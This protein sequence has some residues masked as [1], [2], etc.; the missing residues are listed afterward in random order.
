MQSFINVY[1]CLLKCVFFILLVV[2]STTAQCGLGCAAPTSPRDTAFYLS[3][4]SV[5]VSELAA[6]GTNT[7]S[8]SVFGTSNGAITLTSG[9]YFSKAGSSTPE[10]PSSLPSGG[11]VA[12]TLSAWV[13]CAPPAIPWSAVLEW[14]LPSDE[15]GSASPSTAALVVTGGEKGVSLEEFVKIDT[16]ILTGFKPFAIVVG[17]QKIYVLNTDSKSV[18]ILT[19]DGVFDTEMLI[20]PALNAGALTGLAVHSVNDD[21]YVSD[22]TEKKIYKLTPTPDGLGGSMYSGNAFITG[23]AGP[24]GVAFDSLGNVYVSEWDGSV[25]LVKKFNTNVGNAPF[26]TPSTDFTGFNEPYGLA[27]DSS[28]N[29]YV[30]DSG[31][32]RI[33]KITSQGV[34]SVVATGFNFPQGVA[35]D[36][37]GNLYVADSSN[38]LI[39]L[40]TP[41]LPPRTLESGLSDPSGIAVSPSGTIFFTETGLIK[42]I[43]KYQFKMFLPACDSTWHHVALTYEPALIQLKAYIDGN[44]IIKKQTPVILP[45]KQSCLL[46]IGFN[47]DTTVPA[48]FFEGSLS[49]LRIYNRTLFSSEIESLSQPSS[50]TFSGSNLISQFDFTPGGSTH[51]FS[52]A[53]GYAGPIAELSLSA[54]DNSHYWGSAPSCTQCVAGTWSSPGSTSCSLCPPGTYSSV[55]ASSCTSCNAGLYSSI[56]A[57]SCSTCQAC[58]GTGVITFSACTVSSNSICG[59]ASGYSQSGSSGSNLVC[60]E[61]VAGTWS[62]PGS[63]S[64]SLCPPGTYSSVGASSCT[65]CNAGLY[66]SIG[67]GS[68]STCQ[69]CSG[70]GVITFSACTVSSN[71]ICGC[72]S[73]YSQSGSSG[74]N[75][76]CTECVAGTWS[77]PGS[78][79]CSLCPPGTYSSVG[80]SSCT[81]CNAG[82]YSSIGA[83]SCSTCQACSGTGVITFSACTVSS[84]SICG[85][86]SGYSQSGSSGSNLVCTECVA[87][88]WS[89]P[90]STSCS[91]CP[92][93]TYSS[94]GASSCT[95]CNAGFYSSIGAGS[96]T[97]CQTCSGTGVVIISP[98]TVSS[99]AICG[100]ASGHTQS[101]TSGSNLVCTAT[102]SSSSSSSLPTCSAGSTFLSSATGTCTACQACTGTGVITFSACTVSSNSICGCASGYSQSG[103]SGSNLVCTECVAGKWSSPGSTS[104]SL[105]PPGTYSTSGASSCTSCSAGFY[106]SIGAGSCTSC[107]T[108]SGTGVVIISPCTVSSNAICGCASG[109]TQSGTSGSNLICT[110]ALPTCSAGSTFLSSATGTCVACQACTG[111]GVITFSACTVSSNSICGCSGGYSQSG[112]SGSNLVCTVCP[113]GSWSSPGSTSC[114]L[115]PPGTYSTSS[116]SSLCVACPSGKY[117]SAGATT[118]ED[119]GVGKF[120]STSGS[121]TCSICPAGSFATGPTSTSCGACSAGFYSSIGAGSCTSCP[122]GTYSSSGATICTP[123]S[124][125]QY[126]LGGVSSCTACPIGSYSLGPS[127]SSTCTACPPGTYGSSTGLSSSTCTNT[128]TCPVGYYALARATSNN[129]L[130]INTCQACPVGKISPQGSISSEACITCSY[131]HYWSGIVCQNCPAGQYQALSATT[132]TTCLLCPAGSWSSLGSTSCSLCPPGTYSSTQGS[133]TCTPCPIGTFGNH[134]GLISSAC[135]GNC[136]NCTSLGLSSVPSTSSYTYAYYSTSLVF[137]TCIAGST[138]LSS[139]TGACT[140]CRSCTGVGI[141]T[142][143]ACSVSSNAIC[144]C[145]GGYSQSGSS[146]SNLICSVCPAGSWSS[147]SSTSCSLCPPGTYSLSGASVC[148]PCPIG[149]Y[150]NNAGLTTSACSGNCS[151]NCTT[152]GLVN[153]PSISTI[154][155]TSTSSSLSSAILLSCPAG[156][157]APQGA[158][159]CT[160]CPP[161]TY[162]LAS[163]SSCLLCP[164]GTYGS[165]AGLTTSACSGSCTDCL[166]GSAFISFSSLTTTVLGVSSSPLLIVIGLIAVNIVLSSI[167]FGIIFCLV[168]YRDSHKINSATVAPN[169]L[170]KSSIDYKTVANQ[171]F[172]INNPE[173]LVS[174]VEINT[175]S[176]TSSSSI[177]DSRQ[178]IDSKN[179][180]KYEIIQATITE[181]NDQEKI[182][183]REIKKAV[184][185]RQKA[186]DLKRST[187]RS[188][189][190][191]KADQAANMQERIAQREAMK[192][193][194]ARSKADELARGL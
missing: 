84:N 20:D 43:R 101:G 177:L 95:S 147:P 162:S 136:T 171:N 50:S 45:A 99:N 186:E 54:L 96:C 113:A 146:G 167:I 108:C 1:S 8:T 149:T 56:G 137:P 133:S 77:S 62:S 89:S 52:C 174:D 134:A 183:E 100:C 74:S 115:C 53:A 51:W 29:V 97:S 87:G 32:H 179:D 176:S 135:N 78:T 34:V 141:S 26:T 120:S 16:S 192:A 71:S 35:V 81:S 131:G 73:G 180:E 190:A 124:N 144:G 92:P 111:T 125:G 22:S 150:G 127:S 86:A 106:S 129:V 59:C 122:P 64:C 94:V 109:H 72:A 168:Q 166:A 158:L 189:A 117:S 98:C 90:G 21:V 142:I 169:P 57:G 172:T 66:S 155:S 42:S 3:G 187:G 70:T 79:S 58:S 181:A 39:K 11:N 123:C 119:C 82:L 163:A 2:Q 60:T 102:S 4:S 194:T 37:G 24:R 75:L 164:A 14:G 6:V 159:S 68:C 48:S 25:G 185:A 7:Y 121:S 18:V 19:L 36:V 191:L 188:D 151:L 85:C 23:L 63:T 33:R 10:L 139:A 140:T 47:G 49:D 160:F 44:Q 165:S 40:I 114:S 107:Q 76:V 30:A 152:T 28:N 5:G 69:A 182:A 105:C 55:G 118:C 93:G 13:K 193:R 116:G 61:C 80:A 132:S 161:G 17:Q 178:D 148:T 31:L 138:F 15:K 104:C 65:S 88:K 46:R 157:W 170:N 67:A 156:T 38:G 126:S 112:S 27:V 83:G 173:L 130:D 110:A 91:L 41:G 12:W 153:I 175:T 184:I 145:L 154:S 9:N 143:S 103:S 128:V